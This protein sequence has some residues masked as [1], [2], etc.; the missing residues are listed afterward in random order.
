MIK[1]IMDKLCEML[2]LLD[3]KLNQVCEVVDQGELICE[4]LDVLLDPDAECPECPVASHT[5]RISA[6]DFDGGVFDAAYFHEA[7]VNG[8]TVTGPVNPGTWSRKSQAYQTTLD[9]VNALATAE[10]TLISDVALTASGKPVYEITYD[11]GTTLTI[12][13]EHNGDVYTFSSDEAG[14][15]TGTFNDVNDN[16]I[17]SGQPVEQ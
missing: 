13:N 14:N 2:A 7:T 1:C 6:F 8:T 4:K 17:E 9:A 5:F 11:A 12:V 10:M 15:C 3:E 16:P